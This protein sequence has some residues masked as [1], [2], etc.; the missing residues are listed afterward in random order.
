MSTYKR[1]SSKGAVLDS[2]VARTIMHKWLTPILKGLPSWRIYSENST[3][4]P[5][6]DFV[7]RRVSS[8]RQSPFSQQDLLWRQNPKRFSP[9]HF[10]Q[11]FERIPRQNVSRSCRFTGYFVIDIWNCF[12]FNYLAFFQGHNYFSVVFKTNRI[13]PYLWLCN[14]VKSKLFS[15]SKKWTT[16]L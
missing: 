16:V 11:N 9:V 4:R 1:Q 3:M 13:F 6:T 2:G 15:L 14:N 12:L 5:L 7:C 8:V 10:I